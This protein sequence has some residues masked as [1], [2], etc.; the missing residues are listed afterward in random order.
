MAPVLI[1]ALFAIPWTQNQ[2]KSPSQK[3]GERKGG[4]Y[5]QIYTTECYSDTEGNDVGTVI[6]SEVIQNEKKKYHIVTIVGSRKKTLINLF[7]KHKQRQTQ[8]MDSWIL[9]AGQGV[10]CIGGLGSIHTLLGIKPITNEN[11]L[12][13]TGKSIQFSVVT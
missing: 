11:L 1:A 8:R 10:G 13:S 7:V 12:Y 6:Q 2:C 3:N 5:I 9:R 4:T